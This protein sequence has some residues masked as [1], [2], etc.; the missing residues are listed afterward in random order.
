MDDTQLI[1]VVQRD[2]FLRAGKVVAAGRAG[3]IDAVLLDTPIELFGSRLSVRRKRSDTT[4]PMHRRRTA[5]DVDPGRNPLRS[6]RQPAR[7]AQPD[8]VRF[9]DIWEDEG[10]VSAG[11]VRGIL[12]GCLWKRWDGTLCRVLGAVRTV[13]PRGSGSPRSFGGV[14]MLAG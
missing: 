7:L 6:I 9:R 13:R 3:A 14:I 2:R 1:A 10:W 11:R 5:I 12:I 8:C 4:C